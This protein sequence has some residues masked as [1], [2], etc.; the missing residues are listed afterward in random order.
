[1]NNSQLDRSSSRTLAP[2]SI[3]ALRWRCIG[4]PRG[5]RVVAVAGHPT[6][7]AIFY[8]GACAGGVWKTDDGGTYWENI[9]DGFF[10]TAAIGAIAVAESDPNVIYAGTG[11]TTIRIDVSY[12][13]GVY[14]STD[15]GKTWAHAGLTETR[16]IGSI[17]IHPRDADLVYV[18]ALGHAFGP[19]EER[20]VFRS[21]DGGKT[22]TKVLYRSEKAGA[23][24]LAMDVNNPRILYATMWEAHRN[25]WEL[26]SGGPGSSFYKST[27]GG[28][29]WTE[30]TDNPGLPKGMKGKMGVAVSPAKPDRV[31]AIIEAEK[32]GLHRSDDGGKTWKLLTANR[33]LWHRP[34]YYCHIY[35]D[36]QDPDTVY[37]L[38]LKMWKS[39]DGGHTFTEVTTP[40]GDN[41]DLWIDPHN[42]RRMIEGNDG[43]ACVS[44]NGGDTW[45][46]IYNQLTS[47]FYRIDT[48]NRFPY[49]VYATQQDNS[50]I[51]VPS[52]TEYGGI[53]W[54]DC[55]PVGTGESGDIVVHPDDPDIAYIGAVGSSPGGSGV[56]QRYD[57]RTRQIQLINVWPEEYMGWG[58][59][60]L[61]Y[62][63][64]WTFPILLSPH[65]SNVLYVAG[66]RVFRST[67]EGS[68]WEAISPDLTRNDVTKLGPSGGPITKDASGAE[69]YATVYAFVESPHE[70]GVFWA[71]SDD[72]LIHIS[73]DGGQTWRNITPPD[74]IAWS[75]ISNIEASPHDAATAYVAVTRYKLDDYQPYLY[76]TDDYGQ[77]WQNISGSFPDGEITRVIREDPVRPSL[78]YVGTETGVHF[79]LDDGENWQRLQNNLPI[80]P[81][82]DLK[83]KDGDLVAGTHGRSFWIL[84]DL[85][86]L[87]QLP[88][89]G[90]QS[91]THLFPPHSTVRRWMQ[92][93]FGMFRSEAGKNYMM[94][95]GAAATFYNEKLPDGERRRRY[96][97]AGEGPPQGVIVYYLLGETPP[98]PLTLTFLDAEGEVIKT[99]TNKT[100][101]SDNT[102]AHGTNSEA[103]PD[104]YIPA[105]PGLNR[106]VWDM[107]YPDAQEVSVDPI[108]DQPKTAPLVPPEKPKNG[109]L[110][111]PGTY[112]V[113]LKAG[114]Q[115]QTQSFELRKDP[116]VTAIQEDLD[117][118]FQLWRRIRDKLSETNEAINRLRRM[119]RQVRAWTCHAKGMGEAGNEAVSEA[120]AALGEK[121]K[122]IEAELIQIE[123]N[124]IGDRIRLPT[125]LSGKLAGL[126]SVVSIA[127][128]A[129]PQQVYDVFEH[130]SAQVDEQLTQLQSLIEEDVGAFNDLIREAGVPAIA[131]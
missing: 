131:V 43:G 72:G 79:S 38:N 57:H 111:S 60:D 89:E 119:Q 64:S 13:D 19:N 29:T 110:A 80:V 58:P 68:S 106:F 1:M 124:S 129:P 37:I 54:V 116:R 51:S 98:D 33:D 91:P 109:P 90:G 27:D 42:P 87:R 125:Q 122:G 95:L 102:E 81:V 92:W 94:A 18:A 23:A 107:R 55:Y 74:L 12:G 6:E 50:S 84:D 14:K 77:T 16:H 96:L 44:F 86:P 97:D 17:R 114:D 46:T 73:R 108:S 67:N 100:D 52:A 78:L 83:I 75:L 24:D 34:F 59:K 88:A 20:G 65:D 31:W 3:G 85:T 104:R 112:Q 25:F 53:H 101:D 15:G 123:A 2:G 10:N 39:T 76:K 32:G 63:F 71:G 61:K 62:R 93:G 36:P 127:D 118:Q 5:G 105:G 117:A 56:L 41:H 99:F 47:Q 66:N 7:S 45:S 26:S 69:H 30:L 8:F 35:A 48:D 9:S 126:I 22:W 113:Q 103:K 128:A 82:Y 49:R 115:T 120:A 11:E 70:S 121:L 40:H 21:R 28:D 4:P 130:L